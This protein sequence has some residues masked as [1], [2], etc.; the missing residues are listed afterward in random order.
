MTDQVHALSNMARAFLKTQEGEMAM[1]AEAP[2]VAF[3]T[4]TQ[5]T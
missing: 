4:G 5:A 1:Q 2:A 3:R